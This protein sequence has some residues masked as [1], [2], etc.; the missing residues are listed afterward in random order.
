MSVPFIFQS[1]TQPLPLAQLDTNF[2]TAITL[3]TT[4][5]TL[6]DT[7]TTLAGFAS[8]ASSTFIGNLTGNA[9]TVTNGVYT[10]DAQTIDGVKTFTSLIGGSIDGNAATVTNG[11]YTSVTYTDPS[12]L[13]TLSG[14]KIF[15]AINDTTV[16]LTV[17]AAA[18]FTYAH[19]SSLVVSQSGASITVDCAL[20]NVF[21]TTLTANIT[22]L[23]LSNPHDGQTINWFIT[24][25]GT[26]SRTMTW[27]A[28]VKFPGG[29][30]NGAL[31]TTASAVDLVVLT[32]RTTTGF[33]YGSVLQAFS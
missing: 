10:I 1:A 31:S 2:A 3:G 12:W 29:S 7:F 32:Y 19:T 15:G 13:S 5:V 6:G 11:V 28:S 17:P 18:K 8:I 27:G 33:W 20:S 30:V 24:Q 22:T 14:S 4:A 9:S 23:T 25:D 21:E 16:G 26:G